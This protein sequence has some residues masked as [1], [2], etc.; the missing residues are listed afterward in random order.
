MFLVGT[1]PRIFFFGLAVPPIKQS[2]CRVTVVGCASPATVACYP[3]I[4]QNLPTTGQ[5]KRKNILGCWLTLSQQMLSAG[6]QK[7][8]QL[9]QQVAAFKGW[10]PDGK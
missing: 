2:G 1:V 8:R 7:G 10:R 3:L 9:A 4:A 6:V 5:T